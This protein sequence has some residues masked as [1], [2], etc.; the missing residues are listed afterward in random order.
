[1]NQSPSQEA[2]KNNTDT[3]HLTE[4]TRVRDLIKLEK[5]ISNN[6]QNTEYDIKLKDFRSG[7]NPSAIQS[8]RIP[9]R[10]YESQRPSVMSNSA[11]LDSLK[12]TKK[13]IKG[14]I[15]IGTPCL[16]KKVFKRQFGPG[17]VTREKSE[18]YPRTGISMDF[19]EEEP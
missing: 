9:M 11:Q 15:I 6:S 12:V 14:I 18:Y 3:K 5:N 16:S 19:N 17:K 7:S 8:R 10:D 2:S 4:F 1:M 13:W